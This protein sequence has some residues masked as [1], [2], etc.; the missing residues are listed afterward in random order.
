[1]PRG[2][3]YYEAF[4]PLTGARPPRAWFT[5]DAPRLSLN[6]QWRFRGQGRA[7][8]PVDFARE[9]FDDSSWGTVAVPSHWQLHGYG[10]PAYTNI[11][12]PF[13]VD[14]PY[15]PDE[16]PTG[17]Y[18]LTFD[19]PLSWHGQDAVLRFDG[20][21][22]CGRVW[23]NGTE[24]GVTGASRLPV[25]FDISALL[26]AGRPN[27][28]AVRVHQW[29]SGSYLEDQDMWWLS[30]IFRDVSVLGRPPDGI[31]DYFVHADFDHESG[32]G[33]LRVDTD[34]PARLSVP[35]LAIDMPTGEEVV[36][37]GVHP[38]SAELPRLY[39]A[40][41]YSEGER[42]PV[43][44]GF[45]RVAIVD[46]LLTVNGRRLVFRGV[47][48]HEFHPDTGRALEEAVMVQDI[49]LMKQHNINA[50]RT[51]HYPPHPRFL[52]LCDEYGLW[53][54]DECDLETHGFL[55][56]DGGPVSLN[57]VGDPRWEDNLVDRMTRMVERDKNHPS[58]IIWSLG[59][60][61]GTG[62]NLG[63][64]ARYAR[65]RDP[66]RP[67]HYER[68]PS[69]R[70]VDI[71][72]R[73]YTP[74]NEVERI[75]LRQEEALSDPALDA[76]RRQMPFV[77][78][79]YGHAMGNGPGGLSE[80]QALFEK[81][82]RCQGGFVWEW[83][84]HGLRAKAPDGGEFY[85][86]GGDFGE[87]V[88]DGNF[89]ADGLVFPDRTPSPGLIELKKVIEPVR[90]EIDGETGIGVTNLYDVRDLSH[91]VFR[92]RLEGRGDHSCSGPVSGT[93]N[94]G[95]RP[96]RRPPSGARTS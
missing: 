89:V 35:E 52:D 40:E 47:N 2:P 14:P 84:D 37:G 27:V 61:S 59:N 34:R 64:M 92:W 94:S 31:E 51:S 43:R 79:E 88:H 55:A 3:R 10:A 69:C 5:S 56:P 68:D 18:R 58:V 48:R 44:V 24:I 28:V 85:A 39:D 91:L 20:I 15:V 32:A 53:V 13:P 21:D 7:G 54:I 29:S 62:A 74:H 26:R 49:V 96:G 82:P 50:V 93:G 45:R 65:R 25:E 16:N 70:Y 81:Y 76:R 83:V 67:I 95:G 22:S 9:D 80:Y 23:F 75:G 6:G 11:R 90:I 73:M 86:Y 57:P 38:W 77:L 87:P 36:V 60:E 1:M 78:C 42:I 17:D 46:G 63:A 71:F 66:S 12:Y 30:G 72:S 19:L 41:L 4:Q 33:A 8:L